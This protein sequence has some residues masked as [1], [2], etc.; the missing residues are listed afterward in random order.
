M[1]WWVASSLVHTGLEAAF[2]PG[3]LSIVYEVKCR[4]VRVLICERDLSGSARGCEAW[5]EMQKGTN[6]GAYSKHVLSVIF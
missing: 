2:H 6:C 5:L 3:A 1:S 4:A